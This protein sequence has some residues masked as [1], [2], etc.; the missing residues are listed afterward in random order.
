MPQLFAYA[1][2]NMAGVGGYN[3]WRWIFI[4]EGLGTVILAVITKFLI[5][6]WPET[7]RFLTLD[8]RAFAVHRVHEDMAGSAMDNLDKKSRRRIFLDW[9][10]WIG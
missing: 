9:K 8:E 1:L 3:G 10:I 2:A 6:D 7:A 4:I 5:P